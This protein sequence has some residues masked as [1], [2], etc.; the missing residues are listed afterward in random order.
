MAYQA[1]SALEVQLDVLGALMLRDIRTRFGG[2]MWGYSIAVLWPCAHILVITAA[3]VVMK[4]P[5]PL[6][7]SIVLFA[8]SGLS[9]YIII[10]Y[11]SRKMMEGPLANKQ[12][13]Y[14]PQVKFFD[15]VMSRALVEVCTSS[16][17]IFMVFLIAACCGA[18]II[19]RDSL[20][21]CESMLLALF[22]AMGFGLFNVFISQIFPQW[23]IVVIVPILIMYFTSGTVIVV[24]AMPAIIYDYV[25][26]NPLMHIVKVCRSAFYPGYGSDA[27][28]MFVLIVS[29]VMALI[30]L[31]GIR[32]VVPRFLN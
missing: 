3:Y 13:V 31:L 7:D 6:G 32:F 12:L 25:Q 28:I 2:T 14:F 26:L 11:M 18:H 20:A 5:T 27:D 29:G 16:L 1:K 9:P 30:G 23:L 22:F 4:K 19:P 8:V 10:N 15:V 24:E 17:S 21:F